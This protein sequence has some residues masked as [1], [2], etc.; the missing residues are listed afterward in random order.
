MISCLIVNFNCLEHTKNLVKDLK[1][2]TYKDY[3]LIIVDQNSVEPGTEAFLDQMMAEGNVVIQNGF[4]KPLNAIWNEFTRM[5]KGDICS[6]LNNDI[7]IPLNFLSD[8]HQVFDAEPDVSC[9]I[10]PTNHKDWTVA[11]KKLSYVVLEE[12]TRQGW[13]FSF[14]KSEWVDIPAV[15]D[16]Y[17]GDDFIFENIYRN[18]KKVAFAL[19]SPIIH[20]LSQT[21]YSTFN[22]VIP[23]RQPFKDIEAY[24][25]LGY[26]HYLNLVDKYSKIQPEI[27][28]VRE[29]Q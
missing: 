29:E 12:R 28:L 1:R 5:A 27:K 19:S 26:P 9:V 20:L 21:R 7:R 4:N 13:D 16:F 2:Q 17:C 15:L 8:T 14:R 22:K 25:N 24:K 6:F 18:N 11:K 3:E 10:H 23:N